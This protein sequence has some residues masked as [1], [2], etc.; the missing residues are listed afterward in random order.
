MNRVK[1]TFLLQSLLWRIQISKPPK[2]IN[3]TN[4][5]SLHLPEALLGVRLELDLLNNGITNFEPPGPALS[6]PSRSI[7]QKKGILSN[8]GPIS[9]H[10]VDLLGNRIVD[11]SVTDPPLSF[12]QENSLDRSL[13]C[14]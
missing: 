5:S 1:D 4:W 10:L 8:L 9:I 13:T 2:E 6:S 12:L 14:P 7:L 11:L 3:I